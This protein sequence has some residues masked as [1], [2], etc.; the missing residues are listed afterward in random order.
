MIKSFYVNPT[1]SIQIHE[2]RYVQEWATFVWPA[3]VH[4][5]FLTKYY[6]LISVTMDHSDKHIHGWFKR[7][8]LGVVAD[9]Q[10][11]TFFENLRFPI[12]NAQEKCLSPKMCQ[13]CWDSPDTPLF[14][15]NI[16]CHLA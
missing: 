9:V 3:H 10:N 1:G 11:L 13:V 2:T 8:T 6:V 12:K 14:R 16:M 4:S 5:L 7:M 15:T